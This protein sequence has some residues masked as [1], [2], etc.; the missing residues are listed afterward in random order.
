MKKM[1]WRPKRVSRAALALIAAASIG[2]FVAV[3]KL[4]VQ[5]QDPYHREMLAAA[6]LAERAFKVIREE[7]LARG[8][9]IEADSDPAATGLIGSLM[10]PVT[11]NPGALGAKQTSVN[12]NFAA[13]VVRYLKR[14]GVQPGD[15]VAVGY[16]GS[17]PA[18]N[19]AVVAA[20]QTLQLKPVIVTSAASS[21]FGANDPEL[22]WLDMEQVLFDKGL[23]SFRSAAASIGGIEDRG[24]GLP[25][26]GRSLIEASIQRAG[27]PLLQPESFEEGIDLRMRAYREHAKGSS[28]EAYIN[29]G[30]GTVSVGR[31]AGKDLFEPGLNRRLPPGPVLDSVMWRFLEDGVPVIHLV[32]V[33]TLAERFHLPLQ[34]KVTPPVGEGRMFFKDDYNRWLVVGLLL[35]ILA[36][37]YLFVRSDLGFRMTRGR[38]KR[39]DAGHPEPMV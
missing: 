15:T 23:I 7:R 27:V 26:R 33:H 25:K 32:K 9:K 37:M 2:G 24:L 20:L 35:G 11:T 19:V 8:L 34:P 3:Q 16:S 13:V 6:H 4:Q 39:H 1:Y 31:R 5:T 14:A 10:T 18:L 28:I 21:Q 22:L 38:G 12:P 30:G 17:F 36:A 29:V